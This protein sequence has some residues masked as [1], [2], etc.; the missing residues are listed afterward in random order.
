MRFCVLVK[1]M[2]APELPC[3]IVSCLST[4]FQVTPSKVI[5]FVR[6]GA[7]VNTAAVEQVKMLLY[8]Q[9]SDIICAGASH[10]LNNVGQH[11]ERLDDR[12]SRKLQKEYVVPKYQPL[13]YL[14]NRTTYNSPESRL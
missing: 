4:F 14:S 12:I 6:Y 11:F 3:E 7:S 1:S 5:A 2:K 13:L 9:A 10:C 8:P